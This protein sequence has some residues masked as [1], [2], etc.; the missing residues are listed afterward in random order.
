M[1]D[2]LHPSRAACPAATSMGHMATTAL[3]VP[4][5]SSSRRCRPTPNSSARTNKSCIVLW[6]AGGPSQHG[7]LGPQA[8]QRQERRPL[9][10]DRDL[11]PGCQ[12]QRAH[13]HFAK[14]MHHL[15][16]IRSLDS[17][18]GNHD[19]GTY[20][21]HTGY[22]PNPTVVHPGLGSICSLELGE[23]LENFDLPH[24]ISINRRVRGGIP[25]NVVLAVRGPEPER[26]DRQSCSRPRMSTAGGINRRLEMLGHVEDNSSASSAARRPSI[27]SPSMP[28][29]SG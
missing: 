9:P 18:E 15:N 19:R 28:K 23:K 27:T 20:M 29:R 12:D 21:M 17:K 26:A 13:A 2:R 14:Q 7:H 6:M 1:S 5:C 8:R 10:A 25:G 11:G 3:A 4:P 24:C 16:V 22:A